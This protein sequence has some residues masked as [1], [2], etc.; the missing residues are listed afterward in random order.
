MSHLSGLLFA[1]VAKEILEAC[2]CHVGTT[3]LG[4]GAAATAIARKHGSNKS[5]NKATKMVRALDSAFALERHFT[6]MGVQQWTNTL[7]KTLSSLSEGPP[8]AQLPDEDPWWNGY[9]PWAGTQSCNLGPP[10]AHLPDEDPWWNGSDPWAGTQSCNRDGN[11]LQPFSYQLQGAGISLQPFS[12]QL[13]GEGTQLPAPLPNAGSRH[14][15]QLIAQLP[16]A[17]EAEATEKAYCDEQLAKTK[18]KKEELDDD[19]EKLTV[20]IDQASSKSERLKEEVQELEGELAA[21]SKMQAEMDKIRSESHA[22]YVT[23]KEDLTLGLEDTKV[24]ISTEAVE[25]ASAVIKQH[26]SLHIRALLDGCLTD[27]QHELA[28]S[29]AEDMK[30]LETSIFANTCKLITSLDGKLQKQ[31][32]DSSDSF[33][34]QLQTQDAK[35]DSLL[36]AGISHVHMDK[37]DCCDSLYDDPLCGQLSDDDHLDSTTFSEAASRGSYI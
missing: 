32:Q 19:I 7:H 37:S 4:L 34:E 11:F 17:A 24:P 36:A 13:P 30:S 20:K 2:E 33:Q 28:K 18:A 29:Q 1:P 9:D 16:A 14:S 21:L 23:A 35:L 25:G 6:S 27:L 8:P 22:D 12:N 31:F 15:T 10:L 5:V 26:V 3:F